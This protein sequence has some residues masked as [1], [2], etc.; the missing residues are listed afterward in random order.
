MK[1]KDI[2]LN[3]NLK[4]LAKT[5][6]GRVLTFGFFLS[7]CISTAIATN[8]HVSPSGSDAANGSQATPFKTIVKAA[9]M[10]IPGDTVYVYEGTYIEHNITPQSSGTENA[11]IVFKTIPG[12]SGVIVKH[13]GTSINDDTPVFQL[14]NRSYI[15]IEG[16]QFKDFQFG[17]ACIYISSGDGNVLINNRF[18]NLGNGDVG[19]WNGN[20]MVA[21]FNS[22]RN[23]V[24]NNFFDNI[25]GDGIN[26]NSQRS[27]YNLISN[28]TF[29]NFKG[30]LRSWGG[31]YL[32]SRAIDVQDMSN[33]NNV[34]AF[35]NAE[36]VIHHIWLDRDGSKN[37]VVRNVGRKGSGMVF[38]ES[39]CAHNVI[40]E[41]ISMEM[42]VG[43][44][45]AYYETTGWTYD[46]RLVNNV[47]YNN[48][49]G[50]SVHKSMR[51]EF[52][53]NIA[54]NNTA[55]NLKFTEEA[56]SNAPHIFRNNLWFTSNNAN[57]IEFRGS[58]VSVPEFQASVG[59][60]DGL[61][62]NPLFASLVAGSEDFYLQAGSPA[63]GAA[64]NG[65]DLGAY[66]FYPMTTVGW[67]PDKQTT[68]VQVYFDQVVSASHRGGQVQLMLKL[69][70][71]AT[72]TINADIVPVAGDALSGED[73]TLSNTSVVFQPGESTKTVSVDITG[74]SD[75]DE[76]VA[77]R[78]EN[79]SNAIP[80]ARNLHLLRINKTL[81]LIAH[82][83]IDQTVWESDNSGTGEVV[84]DGSLS[85]NPIGEIASFVWD[86]D[87]IAIATG[88]SPALA[89]PLGTHTITLTVKDDEENSATDEVVITVNEVSGI[90]LEAECGDVGSLW[91]TETDEDASNGQ[92]VTIKPGNNSANSAPNDAS[93]LITYSFDVEES[94]IYTLYLRV[95]C[96][97]PT[98]DSFWLRMNNGAFA[99][100]NNIGPST[101]WQWLAY[102]NTYNL[103]AG[104]NTL[105]IGYRED[106]AKLDKLW[107]T[108]SDVDPIGEGPVA[109]NCET[110]AVRHEQ[111]INV[112]VYPNP[113]RDKLNL[114]LPGSQ[115]TI[116]LYNCTGQRLLHQVENAASTTIDMANYRQG[117]YFV[118]I[119]GQHETIVKKLTKQ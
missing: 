85:Q 24:F 48:E 43:Y 111:A 119:A 74:E 82:A 5:F 72:E 116:S 16:F 13:P 62:L 75:F 6:Y 51:D 95:I 106:G 18:E 42:K 68:G 105:T 8:Y 19:K 15:W 114:I 56:L 12:T 91:N 9:S 98:A 115:V 41:N 110:T 47:A 101:S 30:K 26:V 71:A 109:G 22:S 20:Q 73:F 17:R 118:K 38:N 52:R 49:T 112:T 39:R 78:I 63:K 83:G 100:W 11:M 54:F 90:W 2:I 67:N 102:P 94:G 29:I 37:I 46:P 113:V 21:L 10:A 76:L 86:I 7:F 69:N 96:P 34:I 44:M 23:V 14:S 99:S 77:L 33:G 31:Q 35:N 4:G 61:S 103:S 57:S 92:H 59:E 64:D 27:E 60:T 3:N 45:T 84:L 40:Q 79:V 28:N 89:L 97:D 81:R 108:N 25:T 80:G 87:G 50:F 88:E 36:N 55:F 117:I 65:L 32:Y 66:A 58:A 53:N 70:K 104:T 93:G 107:I 1:K